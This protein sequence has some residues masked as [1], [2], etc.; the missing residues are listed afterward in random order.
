MQEPFAEGQKGSSAMPHKRNPVVSERVSGLARVLRG[1][2]QVGARG[3]GAL[4]RARHLALV[5][6]AGDPAR[7]DRT[8]P[9]HAERHGVGDGGTPRRFPERMLANLESTRWP[10]LQP[11]GADWRS[12]THGMA[13]DDAYEI[14]QRAADDAWERGLPFQRA[15]VGRD[16]RRAASLSDAE[17]DGAVRSAAVPARTSAAS[18]SGSRSSRW[19]RREPGTPGP[20]RA[21]EG[22]RRLRGGRDRL[23]IVATDRIS[24]FDVV[25]PD[26]DPRQGPRADRAV[27]VLVR[28]DERPGA[29]TIW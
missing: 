1:Y 9:L 2:A 4:A 10:R 6:R 22:P 21:R 19:R 3:H 20:A 25:L 23:L 16:R 14:V 7:R 5:G 18:S 17:F 15:D 26:A 27:A 11:D 24:A 12:W 8:A 29:A 13:R 28:A